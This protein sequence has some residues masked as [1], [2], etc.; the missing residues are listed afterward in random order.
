MSKPVV[1]K[2]ALVGSFD[3]QF[4]SN[5]RIIGMWLYKLFFYFW[6]II[7]F[8]FGIP[9]GEG[10]SMMDSRWLGVDQSEGVVARTDYGSPACEWWVGYAL[11]TLPFFL[12]SF[13]FLD[14]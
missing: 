14:K 3:K 12:L 6:E 5:M 1:A 9:S 13:F 11:Q 4:R 10:R 2:H 7:V 8:F